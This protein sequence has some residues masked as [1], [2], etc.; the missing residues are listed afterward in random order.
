[1][2]IGEQ[3][4]FKK[5]TADSISVAHPSI[6]EDG[7]LLYFVSDMPGGYGGNDIW[8]CKKDG[9]NWG[10]PRNVGRPINSPSDELY[11]HIRDNGNLY[12]ASDRKGGI[13]GLDLYK[14]ERNESAA[15]EVENMKYPINS[16]ADD[17]AIHF[18]PGKE[19]GMFTSSRRKGNDDIYRF[20]YVPL[21]FTFTGKVIN[22]NNTKNVEDFNV[23]VVSSDGEQAD[24][25]GSI[26]GSFVVELKPDLEYI[27][28]G[29]I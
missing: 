17:F 19:K 9:G 1:M 27:I 2:A 25:K 8:V 5:I 21:L 16:S 18:Q 3:L 24:V 15:W 6:S 28:I 10:A 29:F 23:H 13:G 20:D 22:E 14:A 12:F 7:S 4:L 11:P 26:E